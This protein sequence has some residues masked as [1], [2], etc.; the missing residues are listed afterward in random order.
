MRDGTLQFVNECPTDFRILQNTMPLL[1]ED[2]KHLT[3]AEGYVMLGMFLEA[4]E[5]LEEIDPE[6]RIMPHIPAR[7]EEFLKSVPNIVPKLMCYCY[8]PTK[9]ALPWMSSRS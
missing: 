5:E 8:F 9:P 6:V 4:N 1:E 2:Q 3:A 7:P